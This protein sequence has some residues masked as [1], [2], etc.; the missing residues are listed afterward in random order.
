MGEETDSGVGCGCCRTE[1]ARPESR[2][3]LQRLLAALP[4]PSRDARGADALAPVDARATDGDTAL[5]FA[6]DS[7]DREVC[8]WI[9][10]AGAD[11]TLKDDAGDTA[12]SWA[13]A[14]GHTE[15]FRWLEAMEPKSGCALAMPASSAE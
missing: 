3:V 7:G 14:K 10:Q 9:L 6:A 1:P 8:E 11:V 15:I 12:A 4:R 13:R 5:M 2:A